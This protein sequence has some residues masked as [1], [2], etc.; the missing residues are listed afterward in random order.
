[1]SNSSNRS[2][3]ATPSAAALATLATTA[4]AASLLAVF[5]WVELLVA[6]NGGALSCAIN[7]TFNCAAV[8]SSPFSK[9][10]HATT[11]M[12][13]A[14]WGLVWGLAAFALAL[15]L[16]MG[17]TAGAMR[18]VD[19][20]A[21]RVL[22]ATGV[23]ASLVLGAVS[24]SLGAFCL[25]CIA[26]YWLV[27]VFAFFAWRLPG[28]LKPD[29]GSLVSVAL[30]V[31]VPVGASFF[32]LIYPGSKTPSS[33]ALALENVL[34]KGTETSSPPK[35]TT[36]AAPA[37]AAHAEHPQHAPAQHGAHEGVPRTLDALI[38]SMPRSSW[39]PMADALALLRSRK[40]VDVSKWPSR[41]VRGNATAPVQIVEFTDIQCGHCAR[42]VSEL[43]EIERLAP[44]N[45]FS[46]EPRQYPLDS[47]CNP[48]MPP[49]ATDGSG[50]R[51]AAA[52]ALICLEGT[53]AFFSAQVEM[54]DNQ[55]RL[56]KE[57]VL[58]ISGRAS[59]NPAALTKCMGSAETQTKL[60]ADIEYATAYDLEGTPLVLM[61]RREI[62]PIGALIYAMLLARGDLSARP[63]SKLPPP[64][65][66][67]LDPH[68]GHAH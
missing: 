36:P 38:E 53:D 43:H 13:I 32:L 47:E 41:F 50:V 57:R 5:Q 28:P 17:V 15:R 22:A 52:K 49:K 63:F 30:S 42:F 62:Q 16:W 24:V 29:S 2:K 45:S 39:Q 40:Q 23:A 12:P 44:P 58:E 20:H 34:P 26:T 25:T 56:T 37:P 48:K 54:F 68:A 60:E 66:E 4:M 64:R 7:E 10:V 31:A 8:W 1:M 19:I 51:C 3:G 35:P 67:A 21:V 6:H 55:R 9:S 11:G 61:N 59:K 14:A 46:L 27:F 65:P 18:N 33:A